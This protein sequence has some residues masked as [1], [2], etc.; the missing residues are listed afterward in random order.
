MRPVRPRHSQS[1]QTPPRQS[2]L[3][4]R[5]GGIFTT[6]SAGAWIRHWREPYLLLLAVPWP[7]FLTLLAA[8]YLLIN[9]GF[10]TLYQLDPAGLEGRTADQPGFEQ[11][12]FFSVQTLGSIGYGALYPRS[13][14]INLIVTAESLTGLIFIALSTGLAF[15][16]FSRSSARI[17]FSELLTVHNYNGLPTLSLRMANDRQNTLLDA[18]LQL[19][20][21]IDERTSEGH[22]MR[23]LHTLPLLRDQSAAFLLTWTAMHP[24]D[25]ASPLQGLSPAQLAAAQAEILVAFSG[26]DETLQHPVHARCSYR[27]DRIHYGECFIDM[28]EGAGEQRL[29]DW[30]RF[31]QTRPCH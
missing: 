19:I 25:S 9:V 1:R 26:I 22:V 14:F 13:T 16:R 7:L 2:Q 6:I 8:L 28:V 20:L 11:A 24:I 21:A 29:I 17:R 23:R 31:N 30:S 10:A 15:A 5:Q 27:A 18:R 12:F 3:L 4:R